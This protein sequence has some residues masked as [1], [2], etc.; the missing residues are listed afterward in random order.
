LT[1]D[2]SWIRVLSAAEISEIETAVSD[3]RR[4]GLDLLALSPDNFRLPSFE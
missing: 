2:T 1:R 4:R 3:V